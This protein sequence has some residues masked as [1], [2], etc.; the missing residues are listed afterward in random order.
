MPS[1]VHAGET[2]GEGLS[3]ALGAV[4]FACARPDRV[5][6]AG[7]GIVVP[8]VFSLPALLI[9]VILLSL[10]VV[11]VAEGSDRVW[12]VTDQKRK[13]SCRTPTGLTAS[14]AELSGR[15]LTPR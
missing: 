11:V 9:V 12:H 1:A 5:L 14:S 6:V 10:F 4:G 8:L 7:A 13:A 3:P 2:R 15:T